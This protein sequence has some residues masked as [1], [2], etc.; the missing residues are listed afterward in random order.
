MEATHPDAQVV[1]V[2]EACALLLA[3]S[4]T[5]LRQADR[6][7]RSVAGSESN[8]AIGLARLGHRVAFC[9]RV[10]DDAAGAWVRDTLRAEGVGTRALLTDP[11][12]PTGLILRDSPHGRPV[13]VNYHRRGSAASS[14][15]PQDLDPDLIARS[16]VV[17]VSGITG[18]LSASA[19]RCVDHLLDVAAAAG[20]HVAFDPNVRLRLAGAQ[21]WR[22]AFARYRDRI[23]TLLIGDGELDLLG[24]GSDPAALLSDRTRTVV[25][26]R[27]PE[28]AS[29]TT[30]ETT[31]HAPARPV[32]VVDPVGAGDAFDAGWISAWLRDLPIRSA[33]AEAVTVASLVVSAATDITG[34]PTAAERDRIL[35][36][37]GADVDR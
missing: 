19:A 25:V 37:Q 5:P 24:L 18:M 15:C 9:G 1:T 33:L 27:G 12:R 2:G 29:V 28:G 36:A 7:R 20:V 11:A 31:L 4:G 14:L 21:Q 6:F 16:A 22:D 13:S 30:G 3:E 23:D 8:V 35:R 32:P 26:K 10:G 17:F 34:L